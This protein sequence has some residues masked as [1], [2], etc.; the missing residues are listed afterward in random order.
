VNFQEPLRYDEV[1]VPGGVPLSDVAK[2]AGVPAAEILELNP[3]L[4][5]EQTPPNRAW[6]VRV[7]V[8]S[9]PQV[10]AAFGGDASL[11]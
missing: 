3:H 2:A 5:R 4:L 7:P 10:A 6:D 1:R 11:G 9:A 8:G